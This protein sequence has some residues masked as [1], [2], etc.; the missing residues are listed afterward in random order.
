MCK[1]VTNNDSV[2]FKDISHETVRTYVF[3]DGSVVIDMPMKLNVSKSGGHRVQDAFGVAHYIP[4][5][6]IHL[7]WETSDDVSF[8]F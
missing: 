4:A 5:G 8:W 6:W 2:E 3:R 1:K 7:F